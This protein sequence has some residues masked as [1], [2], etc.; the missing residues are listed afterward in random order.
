M[1]V[2]KSDN[3]IEEFNIGKISRGICEAYTSVGEDCPEGLIDSLVKNL[4]VYDNIKTSEIRRQVEE[5]LMSVNKK[6]AKAYITKFEKIIGD[7]AL[8][9]AINNSSIKKEL[10]TDRDTIEKGNGEKDD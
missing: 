6:V 2:R 8:I 7:E 9:S 3:S 5:C 1:N 4:Y 10:M